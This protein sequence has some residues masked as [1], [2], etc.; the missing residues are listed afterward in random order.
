MIYQHLAYVLRTEGN[1]PHIYAENRRDLLRVYGYILAADRFWMMDLGRRLGSGRLSELFGSAVLATDLTSRAKGLHLVGE[2]IWG[3]LSDEK[4][5]EVTAFADGI[6]DYITAVKANEL[7]P[8]S[9]YS[10]AFPLLGVSAA[11]DLMEDFT[12]QDVAAFT[13][14]IAEE[15]ACA[16]DEITRTL[17]VDNLLSRPMPPADADSWSEVYAD[18]FQRIEPVAFLRTDAP[19]RQQFGVRNS[20]VPTLVEAKAS[21]VSPS[22]LKSLGERLTNTRRFRGNIIGSNAW[23]ASGEHTTIGGPILAGD[24]HLEL[25]A[26]PLFHQAGLNLSVFGSEDWQVRGNFLAGIPALGVGTNG[27]VAWS[28]TCFYSDSI[29]YFRESIVLDDEGRPSRP[30]L[31]ARRSPSHSGLRFIRFGPHLAW[32]VKMPLVVSFA[33][34][35]TPSLTG[36]AY[37]P[38][39]AD[40]QMRMRLGSIWV[41]DRWS[42]KMWTATV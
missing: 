18:L 23:A 40:R 15:S 38:L 5:Q 16:R 31:M 39:K 22:M 3:N 42:L 2:Q 10:I 8:P 7:P 24:G 17:S 6:N 27:K 14:V 19:G 1:I 28:F 34:R 13:A 12:G 32:A 37:L 21:G 25:T 33:H 30:S 26:P 11:T 29:D 9:E 35:V 36:D 20:E 41:T 4:R